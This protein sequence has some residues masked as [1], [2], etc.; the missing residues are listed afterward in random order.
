MSHDIKKNV[1]NTLGLPKDLVMGEV[2]VRIAG[3]SRIFIEN[4]RYIIEY[5]ESV[6][7]LQCRNTKLKICGNKL[8]IE[9]YSKEEML[10][11]GI[12][13]EISYY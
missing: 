11:K 1:A 13:S 8:V 4:Y 6:L 2:N 9:Y 10:V 3:K 7:K 12:I 5:T